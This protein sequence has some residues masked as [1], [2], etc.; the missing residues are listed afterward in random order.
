MLFVNF[1]F[2]REVEPIPPRPCKNMSKGLSFWRDPTRFIERTHRQSPNLRCR[3]QSKTE[4]ATTLAAEPNFEPAPRFV[5]HMAVARRRTSTDLNLPRV[6][7]KLD[8]KGGAGSPLA[9]LAMT[10]GDL[11]RIARYAK[12]DHSTDAAPGMS[13][14]RIH[15]KSLSRQ[16]YPSPQQ[17]CAR[18]SVPI[19]RS[20]RSVS[21]NRPNAHFRDQKRPGRRLELQPP[22]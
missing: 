6:E 10:G 2:G 1:D 5:R 19:N 21:K 20:T 11:E 17:C 4:I 22:A 12:L 9:P 8:A 16:R 18:R 15:P 13:Y 3:F 14:R 7:N